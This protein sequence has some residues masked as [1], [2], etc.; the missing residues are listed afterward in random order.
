M[1]IQRELREVR[2]RWRSEPLG[3]CIPSRPKRTPN[4]YLTLRPATDFQR[5]YLR[6]ADPE[7]VPVCTLSS[8]LKLH[9]EQLAEPIL[10]HPDRHPGL[11]AQLKPKARVALS[12]RIFFLLE[13]GIGCFRSAPIPH[14]KVPSGCG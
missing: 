11:H 3:F 7:F 5:Q 8:L 10:Q 9:D 13:N 4:P 14:G 1:A 12:H 6:E 2:F